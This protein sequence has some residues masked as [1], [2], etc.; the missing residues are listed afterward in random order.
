MTKAV[1]HDWSR[2][3]GRHALA[4]WMV[5]LVVVAAFLWSEGAD[6][7]AQSR[8][9]L[10]NPVTGYAIYGYDPVAYQAEQKAVKGKAQYEYVWRNVSW[11]FASQAN[12]EV[13]KQD[14]EIY[15]PQYGGHGALAMARG[16]VSE[17]NPEIWAVYNDRL[18][19]F[20]SYPARAAWAQAF[21]LHIQR[22]DHSWSSIKGTLTR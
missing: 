16:Y 1:I 5:C 20:Y 17:A 11:I 8:R 14:P 22:G 21:E 18:F 9:I 4:W 10:V 15:M 7:S 13:F 12:L 3:I 19:L 6:A 2:V